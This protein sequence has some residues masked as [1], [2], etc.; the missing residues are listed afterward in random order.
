MHFQVVIFSLVC[1]S[2]NFWST[3]N[4]AGEIPPSQQHK[5]IEHQESVW[6]AFNIATVEHYIIPAYGLLANATKQLY[7]TSQRFCQTIVEVNP[8]KSQHQLTQTKAT[9]NQ[10]MDAWQGIQ[11]ISFGPIEIAMRYHSIQF[12][13]DKKNHTGKQLNKLI[14]SRKPSNLTKDGFEKNSVCIKGFPAI[15]RLLYSENPIDTLTEKPYSCDALQGITR[16]LAD[17]SQSL[18]Q[19]WTSTMLPQFKDAKQLDGYFEDDIDAATA[20][21]KT[22]VEPIEVIRDLKLTRPLGS[23]FDKVKFKRLESWR[24]TRSLRNLSLNIESLAVLFKS[25]YSKKT[26][27]SSI[28]TEHENNK[29]LASFS[30]VQQNLKTIQSPLESSILTVEGYKA[31]ETLNASLT[32]LHKNLEQAISQHGIHLGFNSRDGD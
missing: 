29:I 21:L 18:H 12:W 8:D 10:A 9:F 25:E 19:E 15:E 7:K 31:T 27:L 22:L 14:S 17:T 32:K 11:N 30:E 4:L 16:Y 23:H 1:I 26:G 20:L 5:V 13:P 6:R 2:V 3:T 28:F 24:S